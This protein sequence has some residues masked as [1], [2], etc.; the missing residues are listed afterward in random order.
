MPLPDRAPGRFVA[1]LLTIVALTGAGCTGGSADPTPTATAPSGVSVAEAQDV[2]DQV[3]EGW[4]VAY[5]ASWDAAAWDAVDTYPARIADEAAIATGTAQ[6]QAGTYRASAFTNS[7]RVTSVYA[8]SETVGTEYLLVAG[9]YR[10]ANRKPVADS[11]AIHLYLREGSGAWR[12]AAGVGGEGVTG[13]T[14]A[15]K[16]VAVSFTPL[17]EQPDVDVSMTGT[18]RELLDALREAVQPG[19]QSATV[20]AQGTELTAGAEAW[21]G[22]FYSVRAA[23][24]SVPD[25]PAISTFGVQ[26]GTLSLVQL[27]CD[28]ELTTSSKTLIVWTDPVTGK[29]VLGSSAKLRV[30]YEALVRTDGSTYTVLAHYDRWASQPTV[31]K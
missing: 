28:I 31:T 1:T 9:F 16:G 30:L 22:D 10:N 13:I 14:A 27:D 23:E 12:Y 17:A 6:Q 8:H 15:R 19:A 26:E 20:T 5:G 25:G 11:D 21:G 7:F 24:C 29:Q 2:A 4:S 3:V 18:N